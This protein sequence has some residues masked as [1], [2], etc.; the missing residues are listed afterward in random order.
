MRYA[1]TGGYPIPLL[2]PYA[3]SGPFA[4]GGLV[5]EPTTETLRYTLLRRVGGRQTVFPPHT[6]RALFSAA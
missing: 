2:W 4:V 3:T 6:V 5:T 1:H